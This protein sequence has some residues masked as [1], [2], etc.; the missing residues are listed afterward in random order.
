[1]VMTG[2]ATANRERGI[3]VVSL[4]PDG[5]RVEK[6]TGFD[7]RGVIEPKAGIASMIAVIDALDPK[8]SGSL[9]H[10]QGQR[11]PW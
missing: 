4:H 3:I 9:R 1:M 6:T 5:I 2:I 8:D 7:L 10:Y 11:M